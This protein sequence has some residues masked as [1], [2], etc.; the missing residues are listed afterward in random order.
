MRND[1]LVL[2]EK[3]FTNKKNPTVFIYSMFTTNTY[4]YRRYVIHCSWELVR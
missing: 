2:E 4:G 3:C 1:V